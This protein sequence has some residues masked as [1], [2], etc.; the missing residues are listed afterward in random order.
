MAGCFLNSMSDGIQPYVN[1]QLTRRLCQ[2]IHQIRVEF[3]QWPP[4]SV[5]NGGVNASTRRN[6]SKLKGDITTADENYSLGKFI[7]FEKLVACSDV[8]FAWNIQCCRAGSGS[9]DDVLR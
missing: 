5:D 9:N 6:V 8:F 1:T 7:K 3:L 2:L 4:T